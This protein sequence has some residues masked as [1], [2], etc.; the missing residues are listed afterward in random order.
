MRSAMERRV[1][2]LIV[3]HSCCLSPGTKIIG[4]LDSSPWSS[5]IFS[6]RKI[7]F[8]KRKLMGSKS[9]AS[10]C[11]WDRSHFFLSLTPV[12][13]YTRKNLKK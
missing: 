8:L 6:F 13:S 3:P 2:R 12:S 5:K 9:Q 1:G 11:L 7:F 4:D 10:V